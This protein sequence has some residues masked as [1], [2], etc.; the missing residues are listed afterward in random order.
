MSSAVLCVLREPRGRLLQARRSATA[1]SS[2]PA[3]LQVLSPRDQPYSCNL[4]S[5]PT[6]WD[7]CKSWTTPLA[8][9]GSVIG[10]TKSRAR[11]IYISV[12]VVSK[13]ICLLNSACRQGVCLC[14][15]SRYLIRI[16]VSDIY[17]LPL[18]VYPTLLAYWEYN[19]VDEVACSIC[20]YFCRCC[21]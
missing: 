3:V 6:A 14:G 13:Y 11:Y 17:I 4:T 2:S 8:K 16:Y 18:F 21:L 10:W 15:Q 12:D 19:C 20:I 7:A 9:T 5:P 1:G